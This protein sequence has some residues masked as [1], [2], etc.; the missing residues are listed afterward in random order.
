MGILYD[1]FSYF[2]RIVVILHND[3]I[4]HVSEKDIFGQ[5][6]IKELYNKEV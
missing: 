2:W 4:I 1:F 5:T 3:I 6:D